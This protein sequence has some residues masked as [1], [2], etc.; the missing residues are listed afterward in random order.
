M[1]VQPARQIQAVY[2][3]LD[4]LRLA[5]SSSKLRGHIADAQHCLRSAMEEADKPERERIEQ[6]KAREQ[7]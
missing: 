3:K 6:A 4:K 7:R 1:V 5:V 2:A